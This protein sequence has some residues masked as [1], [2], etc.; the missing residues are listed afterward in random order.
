MNK[1]PY[2]ENK[3]RIDGYY[4]SNIAWYDKYIDRTYIGIAV[5]Y[6]D[7]FCIH[8]WGE[9]INHDTLGYIENDILLNDTYINKIKNEPT[10]IG[11]FQITYPDIQFEAWEFRTD[12]FSHFG[13][14]LNDTT[15]VIYK[16]FNNRTKQTYSENLTYRFKQFSPKPDS[17]NVWIK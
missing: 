13:T 10:H 7:G 14:I 6:R 9:P 17:T 8:T 15:F 2:F 12:P 3:L 11:V 16:R 5:F 4:Y 1:T